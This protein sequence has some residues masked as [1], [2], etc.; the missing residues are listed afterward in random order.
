MTL[1][2]HVHFCVISEWT[3]VHFFSNTAAK[4]RKIGTYLKG[5]ITFWALDSEAGKRGLGEA[6]I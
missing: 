5:G 1:Q 4:I 2:K 6:G 3:S